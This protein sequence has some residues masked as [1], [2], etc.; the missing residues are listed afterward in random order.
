MLK[1]IRVIDFSNYLPGPYASQRLAELGAEV[2]KVEPVN[3]DPSRHLDIKIEGTGAVFSAN[4]R[5]KKSIA[6]D[7]KSIEGKNAALKLISM[8]DAVLESFRPGIMKKLGLDYDSVKSHNP[9]IVYC[10]LTGYGE[11]EGYQYLGSHDLNY[12]AVSGALA[13]LKDRSGTPIHPSN[14]MADYMGGMAASERI[15]AALLSCKL[16]GQGGYHCI[17][18]AEVMV[19]I[20]GNHLLIENETGYPNGV[21]VLNGEIIAYSIY[22][23]RDGRFAA[24]AALEPKFWINFC[25]AAGRE[26]WINS[27][28]TNASGSNPAYIE[29]TELFKSKTLKEWTEFGQK[30]DCCLS[31]ILETGELMDFPLFRGI[32]EN[33]LNDPYIK[34]QGE[35]NTALARPP[36]LGEHTEEVLTK[37]AGLP[38][39]TVETMKDDRVF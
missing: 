2:I 36:A 34:M 27:Q 14:T 4:N 39:K 8:S 20:M 19:G 30:V 3:G 13:Q 21:S 25:Q 9:N 26:D 35:S 37:I 1:G 33:R 29:V 22:E 5:G 11:K 18:I 31:P 28:F 15:L 10:S 6:I 24:L 38:A 7:L 17:S 16:T 12:M 23:T 32:I